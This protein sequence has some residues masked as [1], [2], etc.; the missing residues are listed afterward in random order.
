MPERKAFPD[1]IIP[2]PQQ[3]VVAPLGLVLHAV[4]PEHR[5]EKMTLLFSLAPAADA[6]QTLEQK[7]SS[8]ETVAP[9]DLEKYGADQTKFDAL[10]SWLKAQG[11]DIVH[12]T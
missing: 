12:T 10:V 2:L 1:S 3:P 4:K 8:G 9:G 5:Q 7:V 11:F 6:Q